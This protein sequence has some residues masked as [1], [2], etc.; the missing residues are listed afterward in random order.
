MARRAP[1]AKALLIE[2]RRMKSA[3]AAWKSIPPQPDTEREMVNKVLWL[4]TKVQAIPQAPPSS[5]PK[6]AASK[7]TPVPS[8]LWSEAD[9]EQRPVPVL[10]PASNRPSERPAASPSDAATRVEMTNWDRPALQLLEKLVVYADPAGG[11]QDEPDSTVTSPTVAAPAGG[12][13]A[14]EGQRVGRVM[15]RYVLWKPIASGGMATV[16]FGRL[17]SGDRVLEDRGHQAAA[18]AAADPDFVTMLTDEARLAAR[19]STRRCRPRSTSSP[20]RARCSW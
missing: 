16:Y 14:T 15:G 7:D 13:P 12:A 18:P 6:A 11:G 20:T 5:R 1:E 17:L 10:S 19:V 8:I 9:A 3:V 2:A 4:T